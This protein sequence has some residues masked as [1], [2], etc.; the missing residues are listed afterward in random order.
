MRA[1]V[2]R[3]AKAEVTVDK[4]IVG[5]IGQ[6]LLV[7]LAV[8]KD[9]TEDKIAK[10]ADKIV[11]LRIF[12]DEQGK[13]NRSLMD[14]PGELLIVPQFTLYGDT[15][16]G[17]RPG[18]ADSAGPDKAR[19]FCDQFVSVC[20]DKGFKT[21]TGAFGQHMQVSLANDGPVTLTVEI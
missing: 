13:M 4:E 21:E 8:H 10:L 18:F 2:Q 17:N 1:I 14:I 3:V 19:L 5:S 16:K 20:K 11:N 9:D 6:G 15:R 12:A 7:L